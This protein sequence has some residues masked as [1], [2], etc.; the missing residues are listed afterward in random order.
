MT[1]DY[2]KISIII[3]AYNAD[4]Y[5]EKCLDSVCN[6]LY[7]NIEVI[8]IDDGSSD[9]T[10][11][12]ADN[13][14]LKDNRISV[15]HQSN[16]GVSV[17]RNKGLELVTG[18]FVAF[19]D[20]DDIVNPYIYTTLLKELEGNMADIAICECSR[21]EKCLDIVPEYK[22][23]IYSSDEILYKLDNVY[24]MVLWNKLYRVSVWKDILFPN[25]KVKEDVFVEHKIFLNGKKVIYIN[26]PLYYYRKTS[27]G[28]MSEN[29]K[30]NVLDGVEGV[31][32]RFCDFQKLGRN[33]LLLSTVKCARQ[34]FE[35]YKYTLKVKDSD[36]KRRYE[37]VNMYRYMVKNA[38]ARIPLNYKIVFEREKQ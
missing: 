18:K 28:I 13:Y 15:F 32:L 38:H 33:D 30:V 9:K 35:Y 34:A 8:V 20:A 37:I 10:G 25:G 26:A 12:I 19:V 16:K 27:T 31:Y 2:G 21:D 5:L 17:G 3:A 1:E 14:K 11:S 6:Q 4:N 24:H 23:S 36:K 22:V 29:N 7:P